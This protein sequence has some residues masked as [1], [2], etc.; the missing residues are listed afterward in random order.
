MRVETWT[1]AA[2]PDELFLEPCEVSG[3]DTCDAARAANNSVKVPTKIDVTRIAALFTQ[4]S[5][6]VPRKS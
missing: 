3:C 2:G 1:E 4:A 6:A 5:G